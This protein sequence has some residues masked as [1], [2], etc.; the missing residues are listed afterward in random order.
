MAR[1]YIAIVL[2]LVLA[3]S[4]G[5]CA[6]NG[7]AVS[8]QRADMLAVA[9]QAADRYAGMVVSDN[10]VEIP[11][12]ASKTLREVYVTVGQEVKAGD[13]LFSYDLDALELD[14][15]KT[16]LEIEKMKNEQTE[17]AEQLEK[18]Q[19]QLDRTKDQAKITS[20]TLEIN[21]LETT[22]M[23][24]DYNI[25]AKEQEVAKLEE[26]LQNVDITTSVDGTVRKIDEQGENGVYITIQQSGAYRIKGMIN[27]MNMGSTL[28][29]GSRVRVYS[30]VTDQ[31]W[32]GT[33]LNIDT[34]AGEGQGGMNGGMIMGP[35]MDNGMTNTTKYPFYVELD[36]VDGLLLGQHV[37]MEVAAE[38]P[39]MPGLW[40]PAMYLADITVNE[41]TM[42]TTASVWVA[43]ANDRLEKRTVT[44]GMQDYM[45]GCY[46]ILSG[47]NPEDYV[48]DPT[49]PGC[50]A[51]AAVAYREPEDFGGAAIP[52]SNT[53]AEGGEEGF[54]E[55]VPGGDEGFIEPMPGDDGG[56]VAGNDLPLDMGGMPVTEDGNVPEE[57]TG[58][59]T[60]E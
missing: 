54:V 45:T 4:L 44:L 13:K 19:K 47:L 40:I 8:V 50:E 6:G 1:K 60:G 42:E 49:A 59:T 57:T 14:L 38:Q 55:P 30:R 23:E 11:R 18:L 35:G 7:E 36:S 12:D 27:E 25:A 46:E 53:P 26:M 58:E 20:L 31:M 29:I 51:G 17:Y 21:S 28:M 33:V 52:D 34:D 48:A 41:E 9:G 56:F 43:S 24:N 3:L 22:Q 16:Q 15:E 32:M 2:A 37:Y 10:V 5:A 39:Q